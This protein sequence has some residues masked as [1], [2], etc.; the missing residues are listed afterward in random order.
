M[1]FTSIVAQQQLMRWPLIDGFQ[2]NFESGTMKME[3][4]VSFISSYNQSAALINKKG[5]VFLSTDGVHVYDENGKVIFKPKLGPFVLGSS[6]VQL[7][8]HL[9]KKDAYT[10]FYSFMGDV[11]GN[12]YTVNLYKQSTGWK[13]G[14]V[15][16]LF[17]GNIY[18]QQVV[19]DSVN[20]CYQV[21]AYD[22]NFVLH[23]IK[24]CACGVDTV[25]KEA[26][27]YVFTDNT[28]ISWFPQVITFSK[29]QKK[30]FLEAPHFRNIPEFFTVGDYNLENGSVI[31]RRII[32]KAEVFEQQGD[33]RD[34][35][36]SN[37]G[38]Y[39]Y[40]TAGG[41]LQIYR[42]EFAT[43]EIEKLK[44]PLN[45]DYF[46][47]KF[48]DLEMGPDGMIYISDVGSSFKSVVDYWRIPNPD[49][50]SAYI[51]LAYRNTNYTK[52]PLPPKG[53]I[54]RS[55]LPDFPPFLYD[56]NYRFPTPLEVPT[57]TIELE[58]EL[59]FT[60]PTVLK[61]TALTGVDST[62]WE[63]WQGNNKLQELKGE[64]IE[65]HSLPAGSYTV[66]STN[67]IQCIDGETSAYTFELDSLPTIQL[68]EDSIVLCSQVPN[69]KE[70]HVQTNTLSP[71]QWSTMATGD[72]IVF[73]N[74]GVFIANANNHCGTA[75]DTLIQYKENLSAPNVITPNGDGKNEAFKV[76]YSENT[77]LALQVFNRW[78]GEVFVDEDYKNNWSPKALSEGVYYYSITTQQ[79]CKYNGWIQLK[80]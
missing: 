42:I 25:F 20:N 58:G 21:V 12:I 30:V 71:I 1:P 37:N 65:L 77:P 40:Y 48:Y 63:L 43:G 46:T 29:D 74:E 19:F 3:E 28:T 9:K 49:S 7:L 75:T 4:G 68:N 79:Q 72:T 52:Y 8:P 80:K 76:S 14:E 47:D 31:N 27:S 41:N 54:I 69:K 78:G 22:P 23:S 61:N 57:P 26:M 16:T 60:T 10:M 39:V 15:D 24:Y 73:E 62:L 70:V 5:E 51:E 33:I 18:G 35:V 32:S 59:C 50:D 55:V 67:Y 66:K 2:M 17:K 36:F 56:K 64:H 11:I 13:I 44:E 53:K 34:A 6:M 38:K 45:F